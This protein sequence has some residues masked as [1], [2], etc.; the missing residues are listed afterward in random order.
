M[1]SS[2]L[3]TWAGSEENWDKAQEILLALAKANSG[4]GGRTDGRAGWDG[5]MTHGL[6][7]AV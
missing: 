5:L 2:T 7:T 6:L 3:K 1:Q 4:A